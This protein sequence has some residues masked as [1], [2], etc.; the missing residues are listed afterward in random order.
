MKTKK[1]KPFLKWAGGKTK[2]LPEIEKRLPETY[3]RYFEPFV[4]G[5][6][7]FFYLQPSKSV[8][9]D[10]NYELINAYSQVRDNLEE[11]IDHLKQHVY[12]KEYYYHIRNADRTPEYAH[13]SDLQKASRF[14]YLNK[15]CYN[16]LYRVNSK[17]QFNTPFGRYKNPTICDEEAL[18]ACHSALQR[19]VELFSG[20]FSLIE[21]IVTPS[22]FI[23][24]DPPYVP[25][26]KTSNFTNYS[27]KPFDDTMQKELC[28][29]CHRLNRRGVRFMLSN[30]S[31][32]L[33]LELYK[34]F[35]LQFVQAPR[36]INSQSNKRGKV[37]EI[38][39]TSY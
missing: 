13:W 9:L 5:G 36:S 7:V 37:P 33:S 10:V 25:L 34:N 30:S 32:P 14:I 29:L 28:K 17:H 19:N 23:Y 26:S 1:V 3:D 2:L 12:D 18:R 31:A 6:A 21:T 4:G 20:D 35:N 15:T 24:F 38:L 22:D 39:V 11:L 27:H 8:L 16:A